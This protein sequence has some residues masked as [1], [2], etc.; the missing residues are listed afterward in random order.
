MRALV[1]GATGFV[2]SHLVEA[3]VNK[4]Y[5]VT[6]LVRKTSNLQ[7]LEGLSISRVYGDVTD[8]ASLREAIRDVNIIF[9][10]AALTIALTERDFDRVNHLGT[11]HLIEACLTQNPDCRRV[12]YCSS[13]A[14]AGP[15][16]NGTPVTE[17]DEPNPISFYGKSKL[18]AERVI[19]QHAERLPVTVI[20][21]SSVY[22]PRDRDFYRYFRL[23]NKGL[24]IDQPVLGEERFLNLVYVKDLVEAA[25]LAAESPNT[26]GRTYFI[27]DGQIYAWSQ[28]AAEIASAL[29]RHPAQ[30]TVPLFWV[31]V[32]AWL[33][34]GY[35]KLRGRPMLLN[36]QKVND[37]Y[38]SFFICDGS[39]AE[40]E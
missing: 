2:G 27:T 35:G 40:K 29:N 6:C 23:I 34:E 4:G 15:S 36:R 8:K 7:W 13:Q 39:K 11:K 12:L 16:R 37:Y 38:Q 18:K 28:M 22:G 19:L 9:H 26:L 25:I 32:A 1:T 14:A 10:F 24:M 21:P 17:E 30:I 33:A 31:K 5:E 20:R 3:L